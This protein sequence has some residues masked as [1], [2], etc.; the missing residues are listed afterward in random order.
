M[1]RWLFVAVAVAVAGCDRSSPLAPAPTLGM[2]LAVQGGV[3]RGTL[4]TVSCSG[5]LC[6]SRPEPFV[7]R[8][9]GAG[10]GVLQIDTGL[11]SSAPPVAVNLTG[12]ASTST[13]QLMGATAPQSS[14]AMT[15]RL[16]LTEVS[17]VLAGTLHYDLTRGSGLASKDARIL[18]ASRDVTAYGARFQGQWLGFATRTECSGCVLFAFDPVLGNGSTVA[19]LMSQVGPAINGTFNGVAISGTATASSFTA[20]G[21]YEIPPSQCQRGFDSGTTCLI[22]LDMSASVDALDRLR[23]TVTYR[24]EGVDAA[25]RPFALN[26]KGDLAGVV[27]WPF[28]F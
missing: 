7:L 16:E 1:I 19:M 4:E 18:F 17:E 2:T 14:P 26:G 23:G 25:N 12:I 13:L 27:R 28:L 10:E 3:W 6:D 8:L 21:R 22:E 5:S 20:A 9:N 15:A 24:V 11:F